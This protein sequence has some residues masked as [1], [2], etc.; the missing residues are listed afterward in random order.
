MFRRLINFW[1]FENRIFRIEVISAIVFCILSVF[2]DSDDYDK[3]SM[4]NRLIAIAAILIA[5]SIPY[6]FS[7]LYSDKSIKI[8]LKKEIDIISRKIFGLQ[9]ITNRIQGF[10]KIWEFDYVLEGDVEDEVKTTKVDVK[11]TIDNKY[12]S[13]TY[14]QFRG[15][16]EKKYEIP[17]ERLSR[18]YRELGETAGQAYLAIKGLVDSGNSFQYIKKYN[19]KY[20]TLYEV[21]DFNNYCNSIIYF[22]QHYRNKINNFSFENTYFLKQF[23]ELLE[24]ETGRQVVEQRRLDILND[25]FNE[26]VEVYFE[27]H[28]YLNNLFIQYS[29]KRFGSLISNL[30]LIASIL[31]LSFI[32]SIISFG[33][34]IDLVLI[35]LFSAFFISLI[36]DLVLIIK[37]GISKELE[38]DE[39][40]NF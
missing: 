22:F 14:Y 30:S 2:I 7:K 27:R 11:A 35:N 36:I 17:Y 26:F 39:F 20:Y 24:E 33:N 15:E 28:C 38:V 31:V 40:Y 25:Y 4:L 8:S 21:G 18:L 12:K 5:I 23:D 3:G 32:L 9:K 37:N 34:G 6:I 1:K 10:N 19:P 16:V 13:L 29:I